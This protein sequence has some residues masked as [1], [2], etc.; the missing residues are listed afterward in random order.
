MP[1]LPPFRSYTF[2][3]RDRNIEERKCF[4]KSY[5]SL[6]IQKFIIIIIAIIVKPTK[7]STGGPVTRFNRLILNISVEIVTSMSSLSSSFHELET[8]MSFF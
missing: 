5:S 4:V 3:E 7:K 8:S 1:F 2:V 6:K